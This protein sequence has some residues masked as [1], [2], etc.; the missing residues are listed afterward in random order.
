MNILFLSRKRSTDIGGLS[1]FVIELTRS[2]PRTNWRKPIDLI[3]ITDATL[4]P[5][6]II[7]KLIFRTPIT[8]TAHGRDITWPNVMYQMILKVCIPFVNAWVV[9]SPAAAQLLKRRVVKT[10]RVIPPGVSI[11]HFQKHTTSQ[12]SFIG[13]TVLGTIGNLV[14][15]KGHAWF[16][17][18]VLTKLPPRFI[19]LIVGGGRERKHIATIIKLFKLDKRVLLLGRLPHEHLADVFT[20]L[21]IYVVPNRHIKGDF[22]GFGIAAGEAVAMG[23]PVLASRVDGLPTV[24][25]HNKNG[26][27]VSPAPKT[28]IKAI[29]SVEPLKVRRV[30]GHRA[31]KYMRSHF[32][33]RKTATQY[34]HLFQ[35]VAGRR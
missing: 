34:S 28:W 12:R 32:S 16:I 8:A 27:L 31:R 30:M 9:D 2:F 19:Y 25:R 24:I 11:Q 13:K 20:Q 17:Q 26:L 23:L 14:P 35:E 1:R 22:E 29:L 21:H 33:W 7:L 15:R 10:I 6:G 3:H 18:H 4:I 5:L